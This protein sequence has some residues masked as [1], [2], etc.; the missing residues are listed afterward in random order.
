MIET[1]ATKLEGVVIIKPRVFEDPRGFFL[2]TYKA[3]DMKAAGLPQSFVQDNHSRSERGVLRGLHYQTPQWQGKLVRVT[4]GEIFDVVVDIRPDASTFGQ[5]V[6]VT[7]TADNKYQLYV[8]EGFAHGFCVL[9]ETAE[10]LYKCTTEYKLSDDRCLLWNDPE[11]A[12]DWPI[13]QPLV[14]DKDHQ[15]MTFSELKSQ[16]S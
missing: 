7:L 15:G 11:I 16:R 10:V 5:W 4:A 8:P 1:E 14:S 13:E 3:S 12:I 9:S 6:G 2:E